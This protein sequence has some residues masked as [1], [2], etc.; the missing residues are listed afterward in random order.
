[1]LTNLKYVK[2][3]SKNLHTYPVS[4]PLKI[5]L[6]PVGR[7]PHVGNH[8]LRHLHLI[9]QVTLTCRKTELVSWMRSVVVLTY[10]DPKL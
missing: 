6:S 1:M 5:K 3:S 8:W 10:S 2:I 9:I 7:T 4:A